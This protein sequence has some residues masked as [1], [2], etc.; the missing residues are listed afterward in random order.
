[1]SLKRLLISIVIAM[2]LQGAASAAGDAGVPAPTPAPQGV[3]DKAPRCEP[4]KVNECRTVCDRKR[5]DAGKPAD[6]ARKQNEC[7]Q[8]CIRGC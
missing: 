5:Y 2:G 3:G 4:A 1:M 6:L 7:K 8:E